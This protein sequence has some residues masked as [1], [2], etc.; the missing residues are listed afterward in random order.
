MSDIQFPVACG[1]LPGAPARDSA[2]KVVGADNPQVLTAVPIGTRWCVKA[3]SPDGEVALLG[4]FD[5]RLI[6]LGAAL[7]ISEQ[8]GGRAVP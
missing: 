2:A 1:N 4:K 8:T 3:L 5:S 6:A 7:I